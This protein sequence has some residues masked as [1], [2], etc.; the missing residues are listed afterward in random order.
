MS[1]RSG[2]GKAPHNRNSRNS[3]EVEK[4]HAQSPSRR[5]RSTD[6]TIG[7]RLQD[8][9][10]NTSQAVADTLSNVASGFIDGVTGYDRGQGSAEQVQQSPDMGGVRIPTYA[11]FQQEQ[12]SKQSQFFMDQQRAAEAQARKRM[13]E[14]RKQIDEIHSM[15]RKEIEKYEKAQ[16]TMNENLEK[17][18]K[19]LL[20]EQQQ[21][22]KGIYHV[23]HAEVLVM[24]FRSFLS[25]IN[26]SNTWLEALI[27]RKSKRGSLFATR[28]K[29]KGTQYSMSQELSIA[30]STG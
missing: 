23:T 19:M 21:A 13:D 22:K 4:P 25:N 11:E 30:R 24:M 15:L 5:G 28:S 7:S 14:D 26:E 18:K 3:Y 17:I 2:G 10:F 8:A 6:S 16:H 27:S 1:S 29:S 9:A 20:L 12:E